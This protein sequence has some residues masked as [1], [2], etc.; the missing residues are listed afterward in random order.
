MVNYQQRY[1]GTLFINSR[2]LNKNQIGTLHVEYKLWKHMTIPFC[3]I[4]DLMKTNFPYFVTNLPRNLSKLKYLNYQFSFGCTFP[5]LTPFQL[6]FNVNLTYLS[7]Q[8]CE[9]HMRMKIYFG[10]NFYL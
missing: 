7:W 10:N 5:I 6:S 1:K 4:I 9:M 8:L 3:S 2:K